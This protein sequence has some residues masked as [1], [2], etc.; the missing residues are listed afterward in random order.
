LNARNPILEVAEITAVLARHEVDYVVLGGLAVAAHGFIRATKDIDICP[1]PTRANLKRLAE[2]LVELEAEPLELEQ[3]PEFELR[4]DLDN[5]RA[6]TNWCLNSRHGR[7]DVMQEISGVKGY[8]ELARGAELQELFG[9]TVK[10][11][12]YEAVLKMKR[13]AGRPQDELDIATLKAARSEL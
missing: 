8:E 2:A 6:G 1:K 11:A 12:S 4:P 13:A 5:L 9:Q 7:L 10:I 3:F